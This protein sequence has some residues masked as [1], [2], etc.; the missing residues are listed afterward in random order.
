MDEK[1]SKLFVSL[2]KCSTLKGKNA[3]PLGALPFFSRPIS[4][5][6]IGVQDSKHEKY[7]DAKKKRNTSKLQKK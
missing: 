6:G 4:G 7:S 3:F 2:L 5:R 1:L